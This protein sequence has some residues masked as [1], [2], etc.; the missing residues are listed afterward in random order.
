[1]TQLKIIVEI[2]A[3]KKYGNSEFQSIFATGEWLNPA[4]GNSHYHF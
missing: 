3:G 1:M 4:L 2:L